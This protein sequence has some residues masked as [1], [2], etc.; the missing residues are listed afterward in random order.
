MAKKRR[1]KG[2]EIPTSSMADI[3]FLLL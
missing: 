1:F 2:G 3:A